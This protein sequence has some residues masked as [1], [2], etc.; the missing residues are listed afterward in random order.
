MIKHIIRQTAVFVGDKVASMEADTQ[1]RSKAI[2][3]VKARIAGATRRHAAAM[4]DGDNEKA[5]QY[6][7][8]LE[9]YAAALKALDNASLGAERELTPEIAPFFFSFLQCTGRATPKMRLHQ[10]LVNLTE[11]LRRDMQ[12]AASIYWLTAFELAEE[13]EQALKSGK[14]HKTL[15]YKAYKPMTDVA[16]MGVTTAETWDGVTFP[17][18][19]LTGRTKT[20]APIAARDE[21]GKRVAMMGSE[22]DEIAGFMKLAVPL[23]QV[24][25]THKGLGEAMN[26]R[27]Y[28]NRLV[29]RLVQRFARAFVAWEQQGTTWKAADTIST[30]SIEAQTEAGRLDYILQQ[31][32]TTLP[33]VEADNAALLAW[34]TDALPEYLREALTKALENDRP[35]KERDRKYVLKALTAH[36]IAMEALRDALTA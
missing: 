10:K 23:V 11:Y 24:E 33:Q 13:M 25:V 3:K 32:G 31:A 6:A 35:M 15:S 5:E 17:I 2:A 28:V 22:E 29:D 18:V 7:G 21:E 30:L 1:Q 26:D 8:L 19:V 27:T 9:A 36:D 14:D 16:A 12:E 20:H 34:V 4:E